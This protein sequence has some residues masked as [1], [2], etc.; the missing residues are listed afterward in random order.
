MKK[1]TIVLLAGLALVAIAM[2]VLI[3]ALRGAVARSVVV[4]EEKVEVSGDEI[5]R[6]L[7]YRGFEE[8]E[9]RGFW[10]LEISRGAD[11]SVELRHAEYLQDAISAELRGGRLVLSL[12]RGSHVRRGDAGPKARITMPELASFTTS[13]ATNTRIQG[14]DS[15]SLSIET[16]GGANIEAEACRIDSLRVRASGALQ[17]DMQPCTTTNADLQLS[18]AGNVELTMDGGELVADLS[19]VV[20]LTYHGSVSRTRIKRSG[21]ATVNGP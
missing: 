1:S 17:L 7:G 4:E 10:E 3:V 19:G 14:F 15:P 2:V 18:G 11:Y 8:I 5:V 12:A 20:N 13:G 21:L 6:V 16:D 9:T